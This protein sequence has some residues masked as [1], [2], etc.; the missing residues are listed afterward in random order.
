MQGK[1][2]VHKHAHVSSIL[3][4][5]KDVIL[6]MAFAEI[7][8]VVEDIPFVPPISPYVID[9]LNFGT[10]GDFPAGLPASRH[11]LS[12]R[13]KLTTV[14]GGDGDVFPQ[15]DLRACLQ[16]IELLV[17]DQPFVDTVGSDG[18]HRDRFYF[19]CDS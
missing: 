15:N 6:T 8:W 4:H 19:S 12:S 13:H 2:I 1:A 14:N 3:R 7:N 10:I 5:D 11:F 9:V 18:E 16:E 17:R